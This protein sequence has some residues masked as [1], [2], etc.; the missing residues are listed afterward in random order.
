M[1]KKLLPK[2]EDL[3]EIMMDEK[4]IGILSERILSAITPRL[5]QF[6]KSMLESLKSE[7]KSELQ[8]SI[9]KISADM[10][11]KRCD[12]VDVRL[13][14]LAEENSILKKQLS[15]L[16]IANHKTTLIIHG[17]PE[18][19]YD[20]PPTIQ[21]SNCDSEAAFIA[22]SSERLGV[23]LSKQDISDIY[24][25]ST[26]DK[27]LV[28]RPLVIRFTTKKARDSIYEAKR[29]LRDFHSPQEAPIYINEYLTQQNAKLY[30]Y[31]RR[32]AK[33][34]VLFRT[35]T[36][37]GVVLIRRSDDPNI[38]PTKVTDM[39]ELTMLESSQ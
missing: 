18:K 1:S 35:W 22:L 36:A 17:I 24:R 29:K 3:V 8:D 21:R 5:E 9:A 38:R 34:K 4:V 23:D 6:F 15:Y 27:N 7:L 16:E 14:S 26:R 11:D 31:A 19:S 12:A 25:T 28:C 10:I 39:S 2:P 33:K 13:K 30:A 37:E 20:S 32:L